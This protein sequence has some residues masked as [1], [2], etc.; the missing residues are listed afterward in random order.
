MTNDSLTFRPPPEAPLTTPEAVAALAA[1]IDDPSAPCPPAVIEA[2]A[3]DPTLRG[4]VVDLRL[5][6]VEAADVSP[7]LAA[8]LST[9]CQ[10]RSVAGTIGRWSMAAAAAVAIAA[11]GFHLGTGFA[12]RSMVTN[13]LAAF[14][15][16]EPFQDDA[17]LA[18]LLPEEEAGS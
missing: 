10:R 14:G 7:A 12:P 16:D 8:R 1:W 13:E 6:R 5:G 4:L 15:F 2:M 17:F 18:I 9:L 11:I 3:T